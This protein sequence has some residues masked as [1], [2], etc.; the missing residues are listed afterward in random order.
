MKKT[1]ILAMLLA[2]A[3]VC[4]VCVGCGEKEGGA[5]EGG[6]QHEHVFAEGWT[7]DGDYH[8]HA[9]TCEH[10]EEVAG[11][12]AH[13]FQDGECTVC[14]YYKLDKDTD[15]AALVSDKLTAE[16]WEAALSEE[17]LENFKM[18]NVVHKPDARVN[19]GEYSFVGKSMQGEM[20]DI[21]DGMEPERSAM[22]YECK[23]GKYEYY[24]TTFD[25]N[26]QEWEHKTLGSEKEFEG[27]MFWDYPPAYAA[28]LRSLKEKFAQTMFDETLGAYLFTETDKTRGIFADTTFALKFK[29][30]KLCAVGLKVN[31]TFAFYLIYGYGEAKITPPADYR[32]IGPEN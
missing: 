10:K 11:K 25:G 23:N 22:I 12:A 6:T 19:I 4:G 17:A 32:E 7:S 1:E 28:E 13:D 8:W 31:D 14:G 5:E 9:A 21:W 16:E 26:G 30:G 18:R 3:L 27:S 15:P 29:N 20:I 2:G 24:Q